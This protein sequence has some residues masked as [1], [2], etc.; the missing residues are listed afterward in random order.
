MSP[1]MLLAPHLSVGHRPPEVDLNDSHGSGCEA[2]R[3]RLGL[4]ERFYRC[5]ACG[6]VL[7]RDLN[8]ARNLACWAEQQ[9]P[10]R[11]SQLPIPGQSGAGAAC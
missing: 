11:C 8:A 3:D 5:A 4:S 6:M 1:P 2:M 7:D 10:G 9:L